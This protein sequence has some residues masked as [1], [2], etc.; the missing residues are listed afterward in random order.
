M[1]LPLF[2]FFYY[3]FSLQISSKCRVNLEGGYGHH[4][5]F[6]LLHYCLG[7]DCRTIELVFGYFICIFSSLR[8][9]PGA[10]PGGLFRGISIHGLGKES[11][12]DSDLLHLDCGSDF[13]PAFVSG[14]SFTVGILLCVLSLMDLLPSRQD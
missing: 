12:L 11:H 6:P 13:G 7:L 10:W 5:V 14:W 2:L 4:I 1:Y 3:S 8:V 9:M